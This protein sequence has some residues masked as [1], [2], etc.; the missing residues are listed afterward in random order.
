MDELNRIELKIN[1]V[2]LISAPGGLCCWRT[3]VESKHLESIKVVILVDTL[4][5][6][7]RVIRLVLLEQLIFMNG[8]RC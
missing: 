1:E 7:R 3:C 6:G 5:L 8:S 2:Q 4:R